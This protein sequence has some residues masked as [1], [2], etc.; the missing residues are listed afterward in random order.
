[1]GSIGEAIEVPGLSSFITASSVAAGTHMIMVF[2]T[3]S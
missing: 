3:V 1:M 2:C